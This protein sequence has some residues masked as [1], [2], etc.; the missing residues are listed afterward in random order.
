MVD[1]CVVYDGRVIDWMHAHVMGVCRE[2]CCLGTS[3]DIQTSAGTS[4]SS[5]SCRVGA[6]FWAVAHGG[7]WFFTRGQNGT[8]LILFKRGLAGLLRVVFT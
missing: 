5:S 2:Q 7:T 8:R 3:T 1:K 4:I 6:S